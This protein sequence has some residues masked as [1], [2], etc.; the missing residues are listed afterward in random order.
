MSFTKH[1]KNQILVI[2]LV[3]VISLPAVFA[4]FQTGF[5][6]TDDGN[7][8]V[9]R[10][11]AF[12]ASFRDGQIPVRFLERLN[13]GYGYPVSNFL[14]PGFMYLGIPIH[15]LGINFVD[16]IRI[17]FGVS[18]LSSSLFCFFWLSKLF[19][20]KAAFLGAIFY[21][22]VPYHLFDV[23]KRG[24]LGEVLS[25]AIV[26]FVLWMIEK[27]FFFFVALGV[28][29]LSI[30]HNTLALLFLPLLFIYSLIRKIPLSKIIISFFTGILL[31]SFFIIPAVL[32]L[33]YTNFSKTKISDISGYFTDVNLIGFSTFFV[34][35][36]SCWLL[37]K[38][39]VNEK[40]GQ[41]PLSILFV[42]ILS[43]SIIFSTSV[44][45]FLWK[46]L[47][48]TFIQFP[49]RLLSYE[50]VAGSFLTAFVFS[51]L[52]R[53]FVPTASIFLI[54][55]FI[56]VFQYLKPSASQNLP[57]TFYSTNE[58]TTTVQDE[59]MPVWVKEKPKSH[60]ERKVEVISGNATMS[61]ILSSA[62][63]ISFILN[64]QT[65][66]TIRINTIYYPGWK[67]SLNGNN[68]SIDY[69]NIYG[70][71]D[72]YIP[73]GDNSIILTFGETPLR[74]VAD[75]ISLAGLIFLFSAPFT[76]VKNKALI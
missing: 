17:L 13:Y 4:L 19:R 69:S 66:T 73:K 37:L 20:Q 45:E 46:F 65:P 58:A 54:L 31:S 48:Q 24:S 12:Y 44:S 60:F 28:F 64:A 18:L 27:N 35:V 3:V 56:N 30:S 32:E 14:Y 36:M 22:Y 42:T 75:G 76:R 50:I 62:K 10:F 47:P 38:N 26:P 61:N 5:P 41:R 53:F 16:T 74:L 23:Y 43:V 11:S 51:R 6:Q 1:I 68:L 72:L 70:V 2:F 15:I 63:K 33:S 21:L 59:Y 40:D 25:L 55:V 71:M 7:W 57:D 52:K 9:I 8:M 34:L 39:K 49:F 29:L 67:A